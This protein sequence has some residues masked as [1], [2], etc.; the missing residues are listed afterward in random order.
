MGRHSWNILGSECR[1]GLCM[2][3]GDHRACFGLW[4]ST[5]VQPVL[6]PMLQNS[7]H[8][9]Q[10]WQ[11]SSMR[12]C[13][14]KPSGWCPAGY[15][16]GPVGVLWVRPCA[17]PGLASLGTQ[18]A[19]IQQSR[20]YGGSQWEG[21]FLRLG[22]HQFSL[23]PRPGCGL[24]LAGGQQRPTHPINTRFIVSAGCYPMGVFFGCAT[25]TLVGR[26]LLLLHVHVL[27]QFHPSPMP[28]GQCAVAVAL[29]LCAD[30]LCGSMAVCASICLPIGLSSRVGL[31]G[32]SP[33][34]REWAGVRTS[35]GHVRSIGNA[36]AKLRAGWCGGWGCVNLA[37]V[38][39]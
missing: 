24:W 6:S 37:R 39:R 14:D 32:I 35:T 23:S 19:L 9:F 26:S 34:G 2:F 17:E 25:L 8:I 36:C 1:A 21:F 10:S 5:S 38:A 22:M 20:S 15:C 33:I 11:V 31:G 30:H 18:A 28:Q 12:Q 7:S 3:H 27:L 4:S 29:L 13:A 16:W